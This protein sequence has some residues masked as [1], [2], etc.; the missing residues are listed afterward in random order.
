M[1]TITITLTTAG[2]DTGPFDLYTD[3]DGYTTAIETGVS[4][5]AL[6]AGYT[7]SLVPNGATTIRVKS[8]G[9]CVNYADFLII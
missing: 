3:A 4:K 9:I 6:L 2:V 7:S 5:A 8:T 1:Q